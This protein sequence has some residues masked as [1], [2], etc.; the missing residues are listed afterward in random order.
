MLVGGGNEII[1]WARAVKQRPYENAEKETFQRT[2]LPSDRADRPTDLAYI[3]AARL[4]TACV[5]VTIKWTPRARWSL[6]KFKCLMPQ[7]PLANSLD[8][9]S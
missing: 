6:N 2:D 1:I 8:N 9:G 3:R 4:R 7:L 5:H